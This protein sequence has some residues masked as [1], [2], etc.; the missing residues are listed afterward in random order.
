MARFDFETNFEELAGRSI[1]ANHICKLIYQKNNGDVDKSI[2]EAEP[3]FDGM[4]EYV[5]NIYEL[6]EREIP[7][8]AYYELVKYGA[9]NF[10]LSE[11][12]YQEAKIKVRA[13][14]DLYYL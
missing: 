2:I 10:D 13:A 12:E 8:Y 3:L 5:R 6:I 7:L 4:Q 14:C 11:D 1:F 9:D